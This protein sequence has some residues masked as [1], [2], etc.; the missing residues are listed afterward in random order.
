MQQPPEEIGF[1][2]LLDALA[3]GEG[4]DERR[5]RA[6][7]PYNRVQLIAACVEGGPAPSQS[8]FRA[9][10]CR[11]LSEQGFSYVAESPPETVSLVLALGDP[12]DGVYYTARVAHCSRDGAQFLVGCRFTGRLTTSPG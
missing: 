12:N 2:A 8:E 3:P 10:L 6:R 9:V 7:R 5:D 4:D 11:D 1:R